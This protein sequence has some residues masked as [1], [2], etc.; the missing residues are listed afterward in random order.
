[1][2]KSGLIFTKSC[3][4]VRLY[5][6]MKSYGSMNLRNSIFNDVS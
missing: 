5:R 1:M 6:P 4:M 3:A 2:E